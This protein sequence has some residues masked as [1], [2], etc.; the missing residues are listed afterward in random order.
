MALWISLMMVS[1]GGLLGMLFYK[2]KKNSG[3]EIRLKEGYSFRPGCLNR[4]AG[5]RMA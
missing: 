4:R 1:C 5:E 2:R 3:R